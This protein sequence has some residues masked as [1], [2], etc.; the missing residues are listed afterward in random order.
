[1]KKLLGVVMILLIAGSAAAA[2]FWHLGVGFRG[3]AVV[4]GGD[5]E[6]TI[7]FGVLASFGDPD[8]RFT[9]Q[10]EVDDWESVYN[11]SV[12]GQ[13]V[14]ARYSGFGAGVFEKFRYWNMTNG[15]SSYIIGGIGGYFLDY[16]RQQF[17]ETVGYELRSLYLNSLFMTA[18]GLGF[19]YN[20]GPHVIAFTEGRYVLFP[21]G[22]DEDKPLTQGYLGL[23]Y[24]F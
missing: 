21:N 5:Y 17:V 7:G 13:T 23:R 15:L 1:M 3:T 18:G 10:F 24:Q 19:D 8:S 14:E 16:K 6:N 4:P 2:D 11:V 9:T 12:S 20:I 22:K